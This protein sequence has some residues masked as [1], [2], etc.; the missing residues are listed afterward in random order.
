M[1]SK[2]LLVK[3][4]KEN[5]SRIL[6][7]DEKYLVGVSNRETDAH[8]LL[9]NSA[10]AFLDRGIFNELARADA[11]RL[12]SSL[13]MVGEQVLE[14]MLAKQIPLEELGWALA[15]AAIRDQEDYAIHLNKQKS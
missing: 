3:H 13:R 4:I 6:Y 9:V 2:D 15:K 12:A 7:E 10:Y 5:S 14:E 8:H 11:K 1:E